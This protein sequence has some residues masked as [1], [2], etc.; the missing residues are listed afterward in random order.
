[1]I[2][3][4]DEQISLRE[5][6]EMTGYSADYIGQLIRAKKLPGK[7]V[8]SN[9]SWVTTKEAVL[10]YAQKDKKNKIPLTSQKSRLNEMLF[11]P[12]GLTR[13]YAVISGIVICVFC[14]FILLFAYVLAVSVDHRINSEYLEKVE[15]AG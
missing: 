10:E 11:S 4:K 5:A 9:V 14:V 2:R 1:M 13:L 3:V 7:Q 15:Y 8:F 12:E 6:A